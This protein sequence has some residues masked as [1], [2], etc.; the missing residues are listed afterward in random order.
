MKRL[1][2]ASVQEAGQPPGG[3]QNTSGATSALAWS[4]LNTTV[5]RFGTLGIG[6]VLARLLGPESYGSFAVAMVALL[7]VLTI[8]ELGVSLAI[9]RWPEDPARI[10]PT[11][12]TISILSSAV[13]CVAGLAVAPWFADRMGDPGA[14]D[15]VRVMVCCVLVSGVVAT[16]A[17][18]MQRAFD[19]KTKMFI[20]QV[21]VWVGAIVSI[22]LVLIGMGAMSLALGRLAGTLAGGLLFVL[23]SPLPLRLGLDRRVLMPLLRFGLPLAGTS[24]IVFCV[25]YLDQLV[26][27]SMLGSVMLGMYVLAFNLSSWP[28]TMFSQPLR[29]VAPVVLARLQHDPEKMRSTVMALI[30]VLACVAFP[31]ITFLAAESE[32]IVRIVYGDVWAGASAALFWLAM[33]AGLR[34]LF[35]LIY[36]YLVVAGMTGSIMSIQVCWLIAL[37]PALFLGATAGIAGVAMAQFVVV[38]ALVLPLYLWRLRAVGVQPLRLLRQLLLPACASA[39]LFA[40]SALFNRMELAVPFALLLSATAAASVTVGLLWF[41]RG[42]VA[43][44]KKLGRSGGLADHQQ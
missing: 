6:I 32:T 17:A 31:A 3:R 18:L 21:N 36:D 43:I 40:A 28:V 12:T 38:A 14:T 2:Q 16:P 33:V 19:Q 23:K 41:K 27:G 9:V 7:A 29:S 37:M 44:L 30:G 15:V 25:G 8:N 13:L 4:V 24:I 42:D 34:I 10:A 20:D 1:G 5:A 35:E 11:V 39:L 22:C 26:T